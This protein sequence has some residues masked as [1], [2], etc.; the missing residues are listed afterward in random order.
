MRT[1]QIYR[2]VSE[3]VVVAEAESLT[4]YRLTFYV[5]KAL[6]FKGGSDAGHREDERRHPA[7]AALMQKYHPFSHHELARS[8]C[9]HEADARVLAEAC[10]CS[11]EELLTRAAEHWRTHD[12]GLQA[13]TGGT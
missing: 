5:F 6:G 8:P 4:A 1:F 13:A 11:I 3:I 10:G 7:A 9:M 2:E 12:V